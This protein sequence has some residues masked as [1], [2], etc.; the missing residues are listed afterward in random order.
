[1]NNPYNPYKYKR[2]SSGHRDKPKSWDLPYEPAKIPVVKSVALQ[3]I[4]K[5]LG[6]P[7]EIAIP[8]L[9]ARYRTVANVARVMEVHIRSVR[10]LLDKYQFYL[11]H[12]CSHSTGR[13]HKEIYLC[14]CN[15]RFCGPC[16]EKEPLEHFLPPEHVY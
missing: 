11:C 9:Y 6:Q 1:M 4:E 2:R 13:L 7:F 5:M 14:G 15:R 8:V 3:Q 10:A 16:Y 12:R